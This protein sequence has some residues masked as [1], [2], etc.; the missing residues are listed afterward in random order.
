MLEIL[1]MNQILD[2]LLYVNDNN[3]IIKYF[4]LFLCTYRCTSTRYSIQDKTKK[5]KKEKKEKKK[6]LFTKRMF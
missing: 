6:D 3:L 5:E 2:T 1:L 4:S